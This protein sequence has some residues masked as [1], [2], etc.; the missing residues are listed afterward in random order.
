MKVKVK[1][2]EIEE[3][4]Y[5]GEISVE[6]R[7]FMYSLSY[8]HSFQAS[9]TE[10]YFL[11]KL[12]DEDGK[13]IETTDNAKEFIAGAIGIILSQ[14]SQLKTYRRGLPDELYLDLNIGCLLSPQTK[15]D[16]ET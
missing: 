16:L 9:N 14:I 6:N 4:S 8:P 12:R 13:D 2:T 5:R 3:E 7:S 1:L 15:I 11:L 10:N